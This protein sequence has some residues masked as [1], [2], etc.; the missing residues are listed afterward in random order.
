MTCAVLAFLLAPLVVVFIT[1]FSAANYISF[2]PQGISTRWF[3]ELFHRREFVDS[4]FLS[5]KIALITAVVSTCLGGM[6]AIAL[7]RFRFA[8]REFLQGLF[9]SPLVLP[10]VII[11]IALLQFFSQ[12]WI[13]GA[14][15]STR[16][17]SVVIGHVIITV[18]YAIR[19]I[20]ASLTGQDPSLELAARGL[21]ATPIVAFFRVTVPLI[22]TGLLSSA[23]FTFLV[24]FDNVTISVFLA[25]PQMVPIPVRVYTMMENVTTPL[26]A[27][28]SSVLM[29]I[30]V[31]MIVLIERSLGLQKVL[32]S[33]S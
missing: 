27:S 25:T 2:P 1:A 6:A 5:L 26:V 31:V 23:V 32:G 9:M 3:S 33:R 20:S 29:L 11:G 14:P 18:P 21:G 4:L 30:T 8:G 10:G 22:S 24:S 7:V 13:A 28:V 15:L 12:L 16:A 19:L 17:V